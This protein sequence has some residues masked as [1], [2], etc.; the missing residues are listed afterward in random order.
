MRDAVDEGHATATDLAD[1]LVRK[2]VA[3][4]DAHAIVGQTVRIAVDLKQPLSGLK[5]EIL[6]ELSPVIG[7]DVYDVL[8]PE[9]SVN[10]RNLL[11]GAAPVQ[12]RSQITAARL[13]IK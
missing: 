7:Q 6:R 8:T 2:G 9:G 1:Y 11:G 5:L 4:R 12:V 10:S 13:L 3:F